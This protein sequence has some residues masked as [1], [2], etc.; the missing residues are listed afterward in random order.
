MQYISGSTGTLV[1]IFGQRQPR[2]SLKP[3]L[4]LII[5]ET[6]LSSSTA[7]TD[8]FTAHRLL[9]SEICNHPLVTMMEF[10]PVAQT[11]MTKALEVVVKKEARDTGRRR[12]PGPAVLGRLAEIGDL[13][14]AVNSLEFLCIRGDEQT[15]WSGTVAH[16]AK[17]VGKEGVP[18]TDMERESLELLSQRESTLDMFHATGKVVYNKREDP[19]ISRPEAQSSVKPPDHLAH[20]HRAKVSE[21][22]IDALLNETGTDIQ[23]FISTVHENY[24]LSCNGNAF[25]DSFDG[26]S[27]FLSDS[28][29]LNPDNR[30]I[31]R[32]NRGGNKL[33]H[34]AGTVGATETLR[35]DE[36]S[37]QVVTRGLLFNLPYPVHRAPHP[38]GRKGDSFKMFYP[39]AL[40]L[41]KPMEEIEA[42]VSMF[43]DSDTENRSSKPTTSFS[44]GVAS[45][46]TRA[47]QYERPSMNEITEG[48]MQDRPVV[49]RDALVL[50]TLP[51]LAQIE[52][53]KSPQ[54]TTTKHLVKI[55][56]FH[57]LRVNEFA[58]EEP[59]DED[60]QVTDL[61][62]VSS[63]RVADAINSFTRSQTGARHGEVTEATKKTELKDEKLYISDDDIIDD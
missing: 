56:Q 17:R 46:R 6:L 45:W 19:R 51:F 14:S 10:N 26:C 28:D 23:T 38:A 36:I 34:S 3:P 41:W 27:A 15:G 13:R 33:L 24:I 37:F 4:V 44:G 12:T 8:S 25:V 40:R 20:L 58:E 9:G 22:D 5:T 7:A 18:L 61:R 29:I 57:G 42:L 54:K 2:P 55:T 30:G 59:F 50:E 52:L 39:A 62:Q 16:K 47:D 48:Q 35:Q 11:L 63:N 31:S 53:N 60:S 21:V 1:P 43:M 32:S 49:S